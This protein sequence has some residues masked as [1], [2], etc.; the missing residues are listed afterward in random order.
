MII[1]TTVEIATFKYCKSNLCS[2]LHFDGLYITGI[3]V[4]AGFLL[5]LHVEPSISEH[6]TKDLE[7][8]INQLSPY[9][10]LNRY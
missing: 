10:E 6:I 1:C 4:K 5:V 8:K 3:L 2:L 9:W 7:T